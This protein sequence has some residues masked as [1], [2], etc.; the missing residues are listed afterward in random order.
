MI[1]TIRTWLTSVVVCTLFLSLLQAMIP[2]GAVRRVSLF[3]GG[4][5]L[6][7]CI[8][9][10]LINLEDRDMKWD[11]S[12]YRMDIQKEQQLWMKHAEKELEQRIGTETESY[13]SDKAAQLGTEVSACVETECRE[14]GLIVP[15]SVRLSGPYSL[16]LAACMEKDLGIPP[17]RQVWHE[18]DS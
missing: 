18:R 12:K 8:L 9:G 6:F 14:D 4:L 11:F 10:P 1:A 15:V 17:E 3:T 16:E 5:L 7:V 2:E 13:I